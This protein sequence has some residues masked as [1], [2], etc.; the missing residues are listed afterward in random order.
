MPNDTRFVIHSASGFLSIARLRFLCYFPLL[1]KL[2]LYTQAFIQAGKYTCNRK[3]QKRHLLATAGC[4]A[5]IRVSA[6]AA[7]GTVAL[8]STVSF[9]ESLHWSN[10]QMGHPELKAVGAEAIYFLWPLR[11]TAR[12]SCFVQSGR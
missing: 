1:S 4:G 11:N 2:Y 7:L 8:C 3:E 9:N 5:I 6:A 10:L 12:S